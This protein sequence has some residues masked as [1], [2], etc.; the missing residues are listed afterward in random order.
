MTTKQIV[1][2]RRP[3]GKPVMENFQTNDV[4]LPEIKDKEVLLEAMFLS[5]DPYSGHIAYF[6]AAGAGS[7]G[8]AP[9]LFCGDTLLTGK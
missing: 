3:K 8:E 7:D 1:L 9:I 4:E 2:I 6:H 5:V